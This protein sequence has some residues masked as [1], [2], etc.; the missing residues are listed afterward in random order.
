[1]GSTPTNIWDTVA[2]TPQVITNIYPITA[3][4]LEDA[5]TE[6]D[7]LTPPVSGPYQ[8]ILTIGVA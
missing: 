8:V 3:A 5:L 7:G 4:T 2:G 6:L 1:M